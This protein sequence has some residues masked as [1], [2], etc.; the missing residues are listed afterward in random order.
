MARF[1][2]PRRRGW[3]RPP[4]RAGRPSLQGSRGAESKCL[5]CAALPRLLPM[6][7]AGSCP[8]PTSSGVS[9]SSLPDLTEAVLPGQL[10]GAALGEG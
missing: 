2:R 8:V 5:R 6:A 3:S 4:G 1:T 9:S 10:R 7:P